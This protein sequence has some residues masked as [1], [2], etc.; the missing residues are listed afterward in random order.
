GNPPAVG[1]FGSGDAIVPGGIQNPEFRDWD[2]GVPGAFDPHARLEDMDAEGVDAAV[3]FP[4]L[5]LFAPL[6]PDAESEREYCRA[7]NDFYAEYGP[8]D[9]SPPHRVATLALHA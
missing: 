9:P 5:G 1:M 3:L 4:T 7:L 2:D 8:A 6:V